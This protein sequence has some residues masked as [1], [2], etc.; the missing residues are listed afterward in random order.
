MQISPPENY[1][2]YYQAKLVRKKIWYVTGILRYEDHWCFDR[3][4]NKEQ[5]ILE[6]FVPLAFKSIFE[7][8]MQYFIQ[9]GLVEYCN[10]LPNRLLCR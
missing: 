9:E 5:N 7:H 8:R 6:F 2:C 10:E 1:C 4:L 3:T